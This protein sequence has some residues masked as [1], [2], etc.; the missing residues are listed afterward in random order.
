MKSIVSKQASLRFAAI[1]LLLMGSLSA[2]AQYYMNIRKGDGTS[3]QYVVSEIDSVWFSPA[4]TYVDLG[5][6]VIWA[7]FNV[8]ASAPEE[9]GD[10]FAWGE[11]QTKEEYKDNNYKWYNGGSYD[12]TKYN[13]TDNKATLE[14]D[15]DVAH[16]LWGGDWRMPTI[17]EFKEL[18][19]NCTWTWKENGYE[20]TSN[21]TGYTSNKIF[22]PAAGIISGDGLGGVGSMGYYWTSSLNADKLFG[23]Y[24]VMLMSF[25]PLISDF[26]RYDALT[27]RPVCP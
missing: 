3:V 1:I 18:M 15:D 5:L 25:M 17:D 8:G 6:S 20:V 2:S 14:S 22:I 7:T 10:Y 4:P 16:V 13:A 27:V 23:A 24:G 11:V 19:D 12:I 26:Q 21:K 9:A